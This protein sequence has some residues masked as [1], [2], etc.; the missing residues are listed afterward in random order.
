MNCPN[1]STS[2]DNAEVHYSVTRGS[3]IIDCSCGATI[4][5]KCKGVRIRFAYR[6]ICP[7]CLGRGWWYNIIHHTRPS[8]LIRPVTTSM[9]SLS[10]DKALAEAC[11]APEETTS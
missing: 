2:L 8:L 11:R 5:Y 1:C 7:T 10:V 3:S 4:C 9:G 6:P